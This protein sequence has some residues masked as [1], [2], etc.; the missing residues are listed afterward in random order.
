[1]RSLLSNHSLN[2]FLIFVCTSPNFIFLRQDIWVKDIKYLLIYYIFFF[3]L[4][5]IFFHLKN[6]RN[7]KFLYLFFLSVIIFYGFDKNLR[8]WLFFENIIQTDRLEKNI[9]NYVFSFIFFLLITYLIFKLLLKNQKILIKLSLISIII[10]SAFNI[11]SE[12]HLDAK[13]KNLE[14]KLKSNE[15]KYKKYDQEKNIIIILDGLV[16]PG[17]IDNTIDKYIG[18]RKSTFDL[19]K[20]YGFKI[21]ENAYSIYYETQESVPSLLNFDFNVENKN[22]SYPSKYIEFSSLDK[23][24]TYFLNQNEF[25]KQNKQKIFATKNR[26]FNFCN[27]DVSECYSLNHN[28]VDKKKYITRL[29]SLISD[30]RNERSI[31]FQYFFRFSLLVSKLKKED[32]HITNKVFFE[33]DLNDF[34]KIVSNSNFETYVTFL[35]YPHSPLMT[36]KTGSDCSFKELNEISYL[37]ETRND[38][39]EEHYTEIYCSNLL[40]DQFLYRLKKNNNFD[41]LNILILSDTG[42]KIDNLDITKETGGLENY[43]KRYLNDAHKV[44]FAIKKGNSSHQIDKTLISSQ[45]LFAKYFDKGYLNKNISNE[46]IIFDPHKVIFYKGLK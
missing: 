9:F 36:K 34:E 3:L 39:L 6:L 8:L 22:A 44:L 28:N 38:L 41:K 1:M 2:I 23:N 32:L 31:L 43:E 42:Y 20:K 26:I 30:T 18:S 46:P 5:L 29:E 37:K 17:G 40:I 16:G 10:L 13:H 25:F 24:S 19:Y 27:N 4:Y 15:D 7:L 12:Y 35:L 11:S 33:K 14:K 21:Y 45:E